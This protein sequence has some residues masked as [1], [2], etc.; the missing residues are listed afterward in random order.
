[1][2]DGLELTDSDRTSSKPTREI[3]DAAAKT[4]QSICCERFGKEVFDVLVQKH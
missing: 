3:L 1:M 4:R 2:N